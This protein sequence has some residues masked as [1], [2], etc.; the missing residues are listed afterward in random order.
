MRSSV[1]KEKI[2][3]VL[4]KTHLISI[5]DIQK[6]VPGVDFSTVFRNVEQLCADGLVRKV[7]ISK[8]SV[9]Y[10]VI[11]KTDSHDH[12]VCNDC[13]TI[14]SVKAPKIALAG[15][16]VATDILIRGTCTNCVS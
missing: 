15:N 5:T 7:V 4:G 14:E 16:A 8:D 12:F 2:L 10:E 6:K 1:Y 3:A 9:L 13:G 11:G